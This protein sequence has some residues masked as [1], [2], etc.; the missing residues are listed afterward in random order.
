MRTV[1]QIPDVRKR[2]LFT[3]GSGHD[4]GYD[5]TVKTTA[6]VHE[7]V[8]QCHTMSACSSQKQEQETK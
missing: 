5:E 4:E 1:D 2:P 6:R 8:S 3:I 7:F